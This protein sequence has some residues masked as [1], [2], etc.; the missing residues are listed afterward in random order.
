MYIDKYQS[1]IRVHVS[2]LHWKKYRVQKISWLVFGTKNSIEFSQYPLCVFFLYVQVA[3]YRGCFC[4][5]LL[6][7]SLLTP[8][9]PPICPR[10]PLLSL[11]PRLPLLSLM[12]PYALSLSKFVFTKSKPPCSRRW[13][14][15]KRSTVHPLWANIRLLD[16]VPPS[17]DL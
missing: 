6:W 9:R 11:M 8:S 4:R 1:K 5:D 7:L 12:T 2:T 3:W 16:R 17:T 14:A 13:L 15:A 10:L